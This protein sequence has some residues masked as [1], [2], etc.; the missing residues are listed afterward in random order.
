M[1]YKVAGNM[2]HYLSNVTGII[3]NLNILDPTAMPPTCSTHRELLQRTSFFLR[4]YRRFE[5]T[6]IHPNLHLQFM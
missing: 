5:S 6:S 3:I 4:V 1:Q 2:I